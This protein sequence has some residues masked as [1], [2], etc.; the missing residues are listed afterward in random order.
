MTEARLWRREFAATFVLGLPLAVVQLAQFLI[1]TT[2]VIM[3]GKLGPAALAGV[4]LGASVYYTVWMFCLGVVMAVA[5]LV[6]RALGAGDHAAL[7]P[8]LQQGLWVGVSLGV[9]AMVIVWHGGEILLAL[10]Q[11]PVNAAAGGD[12]LRPLTFAILPSL[13]FGTLR[14]YVSAHSRPRAILA[15]ALLGLGANAGL[16]H[17]LIFGGFGLPALG[18]TGAGIAVGSTTT[19]MFLGLL[20]Y[21]ACAAPFRRQRLFAKLAR[22]D[23]PRFAEIMRVGVPIG[24]GMVLEVAYFNACLQFMGLIGTDQVAAHQIALQFGAMSFMLPLGLGQAATVRVGYHAGGGDAPGAARA[25]WAALGLGLVCVTVAAMLFWFLPGPL[26]ALFLDPANPANRAAVGF[27]I[28]FLAMVAAFQYFDAAQ[29][30]LMGALRGLKDTSVPM[31]IAGVG[32]WVVGLGFSLGLGFFTPLA[33]LGIWIGTVIGLAA[34]AL[35]LLWRFIRLAHGPAA[36]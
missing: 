25:G 8:L 5:P 33:G 14:A 15:V 16:A 17:V 32:Y 28:S 9:P 6:A 7:R 31:L 27:A 30:I 18:L 4:A 23:W 12:Y 19:I 26:V 2:V 21:V 34:A 11:S 29:A 36:A 35:L 1:S 13:W 22:P 24:G 3:A 20:A 10:G